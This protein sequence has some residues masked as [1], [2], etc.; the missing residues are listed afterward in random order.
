MVVHKCFC[1]SLP[2]HPPTD[3]PTDRAVALRLAAMQRA[4]VGETSQKAWPVL[5]L[6]G[7]VC[8]CARTNGEAQSIEW[9]GGLLGHCRAEEQRGGSALVC[10]VSRPLLLAGRRSNAE[11]VAH[12]A[13]R[14]Q[15]AL[16][17]SFCCRAPRY[18][19]LKK[20]MCVCVCVLRRATIA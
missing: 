8:W 6:R 11:E 10:L 14:R 4:C 13:G 5:G 2:L 12:C 15:S 18:I 19:F 1:Y 16:W 7:L 9:L 17:R 3:R 20:H